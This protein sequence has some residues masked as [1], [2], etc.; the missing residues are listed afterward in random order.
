M[1]IDAL[2]KARLHQ[3]LV[4][5]DFQDFAGGYLRDLQRTL[6]DLSRDDLESLYHEVVSAIGRDATIHFVGNGGSAATPSHSAG[7]WSKELRVR[8]ISH[9]DNAASLTAFANDVSYEDV[10]VGQLT[11]FLR[12]GDLV[13]GFSGSGTSENVVRALEF[14]RG[15]SCRTAAITGDYRG[16]GGGKLPSIVD[17]CLVVPSNSME[18]IEDLQ[19]IVNHVIKEAVKSSGNV[20]NG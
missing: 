7:D 5:F 14:A 9:V 1:G 6:E 8:T 16:G 3:P 13:I 4:D 18:R 2:K 10:F 12:D 19:L 20:R 11:T 15:R 17:V